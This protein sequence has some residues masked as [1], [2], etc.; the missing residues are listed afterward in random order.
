MSRTTR[1]VEALCQQTAN[2][3]DKFI[4]YICRIGPLGRYLR[5]EDNILLG[6]A[7]ETRGF[8]FVDHSLRLADEYDR[9]G[10][11]DLAKDRR[12][13]VQ[14]LIEAHAEHSPCGTAGALAKLA[15]G[16]SEQLCNEDIAEILLIDEDDDDDRDEVIR[17]LSMHSIATTFFP[18]FLS[19]MEEARDEFSY[20]AGDDE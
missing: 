20:Q 15:Y 16:T 3:Q 5:L 6:L 2:D 10:D 19:A 18:A 14:R 8:G 12:E 17:L 1:M 13:M 11:H 7:A 4:D 9:E